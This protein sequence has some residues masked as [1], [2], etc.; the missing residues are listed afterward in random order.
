MNL[1]SGISIRWRLTVMYVILVTT[2][3]AVLGALLYSGLEDFVTDDAS[4]RVA[5]EVNRIAVR[6]IDRARPARPND[7]SGA[8]PRPVGQG[9]IAR[10]ARN[11][12]TEL[13]GRDTSVLVTWPDGTFIAASVPVPDVPAW[14][15]P[16]GVELAAAGDPDRATGT[17]RI[18]GSRSPRA[19]LVVSPVR[20]AD[21]TLVAVASVATSL[22]SG[23]STL[24]QLRV[25]LLLGILA[26]VVL[27]LLLGLPITRILLRPLDRVVDVAQRIGAGDRTVRVGPVD[28]RTE[29]GR[30]GVAFDSMVD[31]LEA[32]A[33]AQ[34]RFVAD[35]SHELRTPL[36]ALAGMTEV[37]LL[38][39]D[40]GDQAA[41]QRALSAMHREIARLSRLA[42]DL[43]LLS[44]LEDGEGPVLSVMDVAVGE[45]ATEVVEELASVTNGRSVRVEVPAGL[46]VPADRDRL[47]QV[48]VNL[49]DN[50]GRHT[51]PGG[52]VVVS[53][54]VED[55][56]SGGGSG[57]GPSVCI[58]V[59]D[60][61]VGLTEEA[62]EH[63]FDRFYR[64]D[65]SRARPGGA[66]LGLPIV[67]AIAE[68]HGGWVEA[69]SPGAG[70]GTTVSVHL[71]A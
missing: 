17:V 23:D 60:D 26:A 54:S 4:R 37:L 67:L 59:T 31:A 10:F 38:G 14:P 7:P 35:A 64:A 39:I 13:S 16:S 36:A 2:I 68:A 62:A 47:K 58:S 9:E 53:A 11:L 43:L 46:T 22:E 71:P 30:L 34:R 12:V 29:T 20:S 3:V 40:E 18:D 27:G 42:A 21:G 44:Q 24:G 19:L 8:T 63:I 1:L 50:A 52:S 66:G 65:E 33:A 49:V 28:E 6:D 70:L 48:L 57:A 5:A 41:V 45:V 55:G 61:G 69:A 25:A 15:L 56:G 32:S 51:D